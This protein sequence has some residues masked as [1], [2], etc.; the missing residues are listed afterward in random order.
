MDRDPDQQ[1]QVNTLIGR[2]RPGQTAPDLLPLFA[3]DVNIKITV[4]NTAGRQY[5]ALQRAVGP[6]DNAKARA[7]ALS[8]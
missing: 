5:A 7:H 4:T 2:G 1:T 8:H 3:G 6:F